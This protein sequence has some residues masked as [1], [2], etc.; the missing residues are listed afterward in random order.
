M[1]TKSYV[2]RFAALENYFGCLSSDIKTAS[3]HI[4]P[5]DMPRGLLFQ[6]EP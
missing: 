5:F 1:M 4:Q 3:S 2:L 6:P